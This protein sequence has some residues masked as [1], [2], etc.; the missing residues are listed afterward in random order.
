MSWFS[1]MMKSMSASAFMSSGVA[2]KTG[3]CS[4]VKVSPEV[5][6]LPKT[7]LAEVAQRSVEK[8]RHCGPSPS[9]RPARFWLE[10]LTAGS[11]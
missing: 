11:P 7:W 2:R 8:A 9:G 3:E 4:Q 5:T 10:K 1:P 6:L